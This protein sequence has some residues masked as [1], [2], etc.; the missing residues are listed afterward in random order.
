MMEI[1]YKDIEGCLDLEDRED[2][3]LL[4]N[5]LVER[6]LIMLYYYKYGFSYKCFQDA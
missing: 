2:R 1:F 4:S 3:K 5:L 6:G